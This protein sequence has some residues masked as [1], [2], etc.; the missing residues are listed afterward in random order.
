[1]TMS[2]YVLGSADLALLSPGAPRSGLFFSLS[3]SDR[4][5]RRR[6]RPAALLFLPL[7][8]AK[9]DPAALAHASMV[10]MGMQ[11]HIIMPF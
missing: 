5:G 3:P 4:R 2:K 11:E 1:M 7:Q 6:L 9:V 8:I 10:A